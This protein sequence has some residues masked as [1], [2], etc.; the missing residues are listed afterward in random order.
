MSKNV[1]ERF[2]DRIASTPGY[3]ALAAAPP[4]DF[5]DF[6]WLAGDWSWEMHIHSTPTTPE[7]VA[8]GE[9]TYLCKG[10][11]VW[12]RTA[13]MDPLPYFTYDPFNKLWVL[14][15]TNRTSYGIMTSPGWRD[16]VIT[17]EGD[18]TFMGVSM[19]LRQAIHKKS[20][21]EMLSV[22]EERLEGSWVQVD[23]IVTRRR[24]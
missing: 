12:I 4:P 15:M 8:T 23:H 2:A 14:S 21:D 9:F 5:P 17:F 16:G 6:A 22:N 10:A 18:M 13:N 24:V 3:V 19:H 11:S 7:R 1:Y 20:N